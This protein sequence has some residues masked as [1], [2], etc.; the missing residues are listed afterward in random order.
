MKHL[1]RN[2]LAA[3][4]VSVL[5]MAANAQTTLIANEPGPNRGVRAKAV[6]Y[7]GEE[8]GKRTNGEVVVEQ[9]WGGALF[10]TNAALQSIGLGVA[11]MGVIIGAYSASE[12]PELQMAGLQLKPAH[13]WVMMQAMYELFTTNEVLQ[14]R[15]DDMNIE[16]I[17][18]FSLTPGILAC[19]GEGIRSLADVPGK[20]IAHTGS[21]TD[22]F[23]ELG[24]NL[25]SMPIYDVYQGMETGLVECSVTYAYYAVAT[26]LNEL[27]G[28]VTDMHF[29]SLASL[30]TFMNKDTFNA[31]TPEQQ[32]IVKEVGRDV[33]D[34]YGENLAAADIKAMETLTTGDKAADLVELP[35]EDYARIGDLFK[36]SIENW[37]ADAAGVGTDGEALMAELF[38]LIDK[39][40]AVMETEGLPWER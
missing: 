35:A 10:K 2:I 14:A 20:K 22:I 36:P 30:A 21:S 38:T 39:W 8:I 1:T 4:S 18:T 17:S 27:V 16:Y 29:S 28:T 7:I 11:D 19:S 24:G 26:K 31:L 5:A 37:K 34:F 6:A 13:P 12:F 3:A 33:M 32:K 40:T 9:N 23:G 25:V 15:F